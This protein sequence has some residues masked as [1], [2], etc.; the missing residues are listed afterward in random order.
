MK[1]TITLFLLSVC[2]TFFGQN[3]DAIYDVIAKETCECVSN[4]KLDLANDDLEKV[5][6]EFGFCMINSYSN[7]KND[8]DE[9]IDLDFGNSELMGKFGEDIALKMV[10]HCPDFII[11]L[12]SRGDVSEEEEEIPNSTLEAFF[13]ESKKN[14]FQTITVKE[15][16]GRLHILIVLTFF[17]NVNLITENVIKKNEKVEVEYFEQEFYDPKVNDFRYYKV[18]Q[19]IKKL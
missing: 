4:K 1:G 16:N 15:S 3:K 6:I 12:G 19:G 9:P 11:A 5:Q 13:V 7:H 14:D 8:F 2:T 17:E 10:N 18:I